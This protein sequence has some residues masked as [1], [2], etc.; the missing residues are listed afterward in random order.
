MA[1]TFDCPHG[2]DL[3]SVQCG[4]CKQDR[5][6][7]KKAEEAVEALGRGVNGGRPAVTA[8]A[9]N[10]EHA[11]L[12]QK[13]AEAMAMSTLARTYDSL[14]PMVAA[15]TTVFDDA[16]PEHDG[17]LSCGT[18]IGALRTLAVRPQDDVLEARRYWLG[19]TY[20]PGY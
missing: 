10:R 5:E 14:C 19:R 3:Y 12:F 20:Q 8:A 1:V 6:Q 16:H 18:V 2:N 15:K 7:Y 11:Y 13:L 17:R 4:L 9:L